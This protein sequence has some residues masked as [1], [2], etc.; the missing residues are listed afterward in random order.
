MSDLLA[1]NFRYRRSFAKT[2]PAVDVD[3]LIQIQRD[4]YEKFLQMKIP[5]TEREG[6]GLQGVFKSVSRFRT[7]AIGRA[8][9][10]SPMTWRFPSTM[11]MSAASA[12]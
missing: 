3:N 7:S 4:S 11:W 9:S 2:L 12:A 6:I 10:L 1:N 8:S 5:R